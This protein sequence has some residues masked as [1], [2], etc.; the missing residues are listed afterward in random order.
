M[1]FLLFN[2]IKLIGKRGLL[3]EPP[4]MGAAIPDMLHE[5]WHRHLSS[6]S[7][8]LYLSYE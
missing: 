7:S 2:A 1:E 4:A 3:S 6:G 5:D 8:S